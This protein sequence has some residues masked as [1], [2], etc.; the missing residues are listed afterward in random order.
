MGR[1]RDRFKASDNVMST[2]RSAWNTA[3]KLYRTF[4]T[5]T[6]ADAA[7]KVNRD[8]G[9]PQYTTIVIP[10]SYATLLTAHTFWASVFLGRTPIFQYAARHGEVQDKVLAVEALIDY[11]VRQAGM[12]PILFQWLLDTGKYGLG[13][14]S[15]FWTEQVI[16]TTTSTKVNAS[17]SVLENPDAETEE[18]T[19]ERKGYQ[20]N[21]LFNI[22]P[23]DFFPDPAVSV[24]RL[25]KGEYYGRLF[26]VGWNTIQRGRINGTYFNIDELEKRVRG[27]GLPREG[28]SVVDLPHEQDAALNSEYGKLK[29]ERH[30]SVQLFEITV[31]LIPSIW[32]FGKSDYPE[33]WLLTLAQGDVLIA[34][35]PL[36]KDGDTFPIF[37]NTYEID[38]YSFTGRG[39]L[40]IL[41][42]LNDT[43]D[44][45]LHTHFMNVRKSLNDQFLIDPNKVQM[46]DFERG[47]A[48]RLIR[49]KPSAYGTDLRSV[50]MQLP[51]QDITRANI[52]DLELILKFMEK[53]AGVNENMMGVPTQ[54][55]RKT[56]T[57]IRSTSTLGINRQKTF[58]EYNSALGWG[59]LAQDLLQNSQ[60]YY[61]DDEMF[62]IVGDNVPK[63]E[64]LFAKVTPA[65]IRGS[66][67]YIP[68]DGT[69]PID[70]FA[71]AQVFQGLVQTMA[72]VPDLLQ[73]FDLGGIINF[74]AS[75]M[76][77]KNLGSFKTQVVSDEDALR[78]EQNGDLV[79]APVIEGGT[80]NAII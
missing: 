34:A 43:A 59:P 48:G 49:L 72:Q 29:T 41:K 8:A 74:I 28:S 42:P 25:Q 32:E 37:V 12:V 24:T 79:P 61:K 16:R 6:S 39:M 73:G 60:Q 54:G 63:G 15:D 9:E 33:K 1:I 50:F 2:R 20:G 10:L 21:E 51:V 44:W 4:T 17:L 46:S 66:Y 71:Q 53:V 76:G 40:E 77:I 58:A 38:A 80:G 3:D 47:G 52:S 75:L 27:V 35:E 67:D 26:E 56:A 13:V 11:Q 70:R 30:G 7:R 23:H 64:P 19:E 65:S 36:G 62:R 57:E 45:L 5:E 14:T 22:R 78:G 69:F 31:E 55:G 68:V 18:K